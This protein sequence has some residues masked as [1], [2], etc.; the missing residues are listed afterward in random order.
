MKGGEKRIKQDYN[1]D[2]TEELRRMMIHHDRRHGNEQGGGP[3]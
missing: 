3:S 2:F 1:I